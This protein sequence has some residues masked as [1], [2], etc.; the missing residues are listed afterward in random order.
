MQDFE[1]ID[2]CLPGHPLSNLTVLLVLHEKVHARYLAYPQ[3]LDEPMALSL[4]F[5]QQLD[6]RFPPKLAC[7]NHTI[8]LSHV[9]DRPPRYIAAAFLLLGVLLWSI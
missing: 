1:F 8:A 3:Y 2:T 5:A 9:L 4:V 6:N 7:G